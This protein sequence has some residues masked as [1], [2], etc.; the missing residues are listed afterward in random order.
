MRGCRNWITTPVAAAA[1]LLICQTA[2]AVV[3]AP[4]CNIT[5]AIASLELRGKI[6]VTCP[7]ACKSKTCRSQCRRLRVKSH[8]QQLDYGSSQTRPRYRVAPHH[9]P[10]YYV[11]HGPWL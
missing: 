9:L 6:A 4:R 5:A 11:L 1:A 3:P 8:Y 2:Q 10:D 7:T